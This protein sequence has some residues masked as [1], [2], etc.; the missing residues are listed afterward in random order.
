MSD[1]PGP[2]LFVI[3]GDHPI[4]QSDHQIRQLK[5]IGLRAGDS[6]PGAAQFVTQHPDRA[7]L[8]GR[9]VGKGPRRKLLDPFADAGKRIRAILDAG[10]FDDLERVCRQK[11]IPPQARPLERAFQEHHKRFA[12]PG[13]ECLPDVGKGNEFFHKGKRKRFVGCQFR[14]HP[15]DNNKP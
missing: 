14:H 8:K 13:L 11:G 10:D 3:P 4:E 2:V 1:D 7:A 9:Q 5:L 15:R 6:F 12:R